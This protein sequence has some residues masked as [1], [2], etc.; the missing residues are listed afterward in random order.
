MQRLVGYR[1]GLLGKRPPYALR[2]AQQQVVLVR[3]NKAA[4][5][6]GP[7]T[8]VYKHFTPRSVE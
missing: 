8:V 6:G 7:A 4:R 5:G 2:T 3:H 1:G